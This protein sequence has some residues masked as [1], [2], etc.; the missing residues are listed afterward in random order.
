MKTRFYV[1]IIILS[2]LSIFS[3]L[4]IQPTVK[5]LDDS[6]QLGKT[7][8]NYSS[9]VEKARMN[10]S[11]DTSNGYQFYPGG[12]EKFDKEYNKIME[13]RNELYN[14]SDSFT[15]Y[16]SNLSKAEKVAFIASKVIAIVFYATVIIT[17]LMFWMAYAI[18]TLKRKARKEKRKRYSKKVTV[19]NR[20]VC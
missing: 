20:K 15:N 17:C 16:F 9:E 19:L 13:K 14:S 1:I 5:E 11:Y 4:L 12:Q 8:S 7:L 6:F 2:V 3:L 18:I 10:Y